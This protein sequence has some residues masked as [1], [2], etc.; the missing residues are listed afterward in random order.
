MVEKQELMEKFQR[1]EI[2][3]ENLRENQGEKRRELQKE[4]DFLTNE[5]NHKQLEQ[6]ELKEKLRKREDELRDL[7]QNLNE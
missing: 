6:S 5:L 1:I 2:E 4:I 7:K 3:M